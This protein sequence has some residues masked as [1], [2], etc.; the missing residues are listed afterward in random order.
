MVAFLNAAVLGACGGSSVADSAGGRA[1]LLGT[2][3]S[4][5][6]LQ[7]SVDQ[8]TGILTQRCMASHGLSYYPFPQQGQPGGSPLFASQLFG[9]S[10]WLGPQSVAW[11]SLNGWGL[12]E[13]TMQRL[14]QPGGFLGGAPQ[15]SE[16]FRSLRGRALGNYF[17]TL[18]GGGK[19]MKIR[20]PG[21]P[22]MT[23]QIGGCNTTAG[24]QLFGSVAA[25]VAVPRYGPSVLN[26]TIESSAGR[27]PALRAA[28]ARWAACVRARTGVTARSPSQ[29][30]LH[31]YQLYNT[32]GPTPA[33]HGDEL[34]A[35]V[36]DLTC[37]RQSRL[38]QTM[39]SAELAAVGRLPGSVV[40]ELQTLLADLQLA[41]SKAR[42]LLSKAPTTSGSTT[43]SPASPSPVAPGV[44]IGPGPGGF[45]GR[46]VIVGG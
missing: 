32:K 42:S 38:P 40:G 44:G 4:W 31:Y 43:T 37:Q 22:R 11:R 39:R 10:L 20:I 36:A 15:Q 35:A 9:S 18:Y 25:S 41:E 6:A 1:A 2:L 3:E 46:V 12:Y 28:E 27:A 45:G 5:S 14:S 8:A 30:F 23:I 17:K 19:T 33:V 24:K 29:L 16:M 34:S 26:G 13:E 7:T 21:L